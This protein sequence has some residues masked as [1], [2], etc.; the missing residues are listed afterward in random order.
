MRKLTICLAVVGLFGV[1][2]LADTAISG[3]LE[4]VHSVDIHVDMDS[5]TGLT[6]DGELLW[7]T[8]AIPG[9]KPLGD[10]FP[11]NGPFTYLHGLDPSDGSPQSYFRQSNYLFN[12]SGLVWDGEHFWI[13]AF[14]ELLDVPVD[15]LGDPIYR[16]SQDGTQI[17]TIAAPLSPDARPTGLAWDGTHLW[18]SDRRHDKIMQVDP[19]DMSVISSFDSPGDEP[20]GLT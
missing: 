3:E 11:P 6:W 13:A 14:F 17:E 18:L 8:G 20:R 19:A 15:M 16:I 2:C 7:V 12:A 5:G 4:V 1:M 10:G 9:H